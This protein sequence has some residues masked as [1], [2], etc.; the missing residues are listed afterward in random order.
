VKFLQ[1]DES[2]F[3]FCD[4]LSNFSQPRGCFAGIL[5]GFQHVFEF[6]FW[7]IA[8]ATQRDSKRLGESFAAR[9][10][11]PSIA[12][13]K[14]CLLQGRNGREDFDRQEESRA[15]RAR[16]QD[17]CRAKKLFFSRLC[18]SVERWS[19]SAARA[20]A[21]IFPRVMEAKKKGF[22]FF[23]FFVL[24]VFSSGK[25]STALLLKAEERFVNALM[26]FPLWCRTWRRSRN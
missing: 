20:R 25:L 17:S 1:G 10:D 16:R 9:S 18:V 4:A 22:F 5:A 26:R 6:V 7:E 15:G 19:C 24:I 2:F 3:L 13:R 12:K 23:F 21:T 14:Y 11:C 8:G